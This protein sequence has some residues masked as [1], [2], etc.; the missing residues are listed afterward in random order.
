MTGGKSNS[1]PYV[2]IDVKETVT[3]S[4]EKIED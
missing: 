4:V 3:Y 2:D 1:L